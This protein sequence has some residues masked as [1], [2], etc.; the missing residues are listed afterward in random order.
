MSY[1]KL[2]GHM[3]EFAQTGEFYVCNAEMVF[4]RQD[5]V[6]TSFTTEV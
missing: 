3:C 1:T 5:L 6:L 4:S 2:Y